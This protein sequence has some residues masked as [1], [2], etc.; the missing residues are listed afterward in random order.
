MGVANSASR[1]TATG[2]NATSYQTV[3]R[4]GAS[5]LSVFLRRVSGSGTIQ[6]TKDGGSTFGA[7]QWIAMGEVGEYF[8]RA[9]LNRV[10]RG[11]NWVCEIAVTDPVLVALIQC[12]VD[13]ERGV[14]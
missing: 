11:R 14:S 1:L 12:T 10:G 13:A 3:T 7:E 6:I 9:Y 4:T 8:R 5:F 2:A